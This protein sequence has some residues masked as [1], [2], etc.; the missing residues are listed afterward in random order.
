MFKGVNRQLYNPEIAK[1]DFSDIKGNLSVAK[2]LRSTVVKS[3]SNMS[4]YIVAISGNLECAM[5]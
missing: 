2:S 5:V 4:T 3:H 1:C